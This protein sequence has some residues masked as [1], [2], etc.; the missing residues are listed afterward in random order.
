MPVSS[1]S[2]PGWA[3]GSPAVAPPMEAVGAFFGALLGSAQNGSLDGLRLGTLAGPPVFVGSDV[4]PAKP[5]TSSKANRVVPLTHRPPPGEPIC[6]PRCIGTLP[7]NRYRVKAES[8]PQGKWAGR[9]VC[10]NVQP[11]R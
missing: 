1:G 5:R 11:R 9:L 4:Q 6:R 2:L 7:G 10:K 3:N 8:R